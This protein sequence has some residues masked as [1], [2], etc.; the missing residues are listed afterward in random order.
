MPVSRRPK[1]D[2]VAAR[3]WGTPQ[4]GRVRVN[5]H[6]ATATRC[7]ATLLPQSVAGLSAV[8]TPRGE[9]YR[10][11][12]GGFWWETHTLQG[13]LLRCLPYQ[14]RCHRCQVQVH[15]HQPLTLYWQRWQRLKKGREVQKGFWGCLVC[16]LGPAE[17]G[18]RILSNHLGDSA[19]APYRRSDPRSVTPCPSGPPWLG[20]PGTP[21]SRLSFRT[22]M[23]SKRHPTRDVRV[24]VSPASMKST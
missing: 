5:V 16:G 2:E 22:S 8:A 23:T 10:K 18:T 24:R 1:S 13:C 7:R 15:Q 19:P 11:D 3:E 6:M 12:F 21:D 14:D 17:R 4:D 20:V 9:K